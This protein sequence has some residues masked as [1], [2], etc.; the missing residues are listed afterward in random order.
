MP[1]ATEI[2]PAAF[3]PTAPAFLEREVREVMTPGVLTIVEDAS[4]RQARRAMRA[5]GIHAVLVVGKLQGRPLG[6]VTARGLL[7][8]IGRDDSMAASRDAITERP[9]GIEPSAQVRD[10]VRAL[11]QPGVS[12]LLVQRRPDVL[13]EG[14]VSDVDLIGLG[15]R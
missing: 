2:L 5:H 12:H 14:V 10:A 15:E 7:D 3:G 1:A 6:W 4:V 11:S 13:P 9:A 8:W